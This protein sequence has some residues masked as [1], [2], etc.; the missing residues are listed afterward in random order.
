MV[1]LGFQGVQTVKF[2]ITVVYLAHKVFLYVSKGLLG[3]RVYLEKLID[4]PTGTFTTR[5][6]GW[7]YEMSTLLDKSIK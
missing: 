3:T 4:G 7:V 6:G 2:N 1:F 5:V